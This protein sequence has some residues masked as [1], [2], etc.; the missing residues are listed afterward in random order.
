MSFKHN[1]VVR[2]NNLADFGIDKLPLGA[3]VQQGNN[4]YVLEDTSGLTSSTSISTAITNSNLIKRTDSSEFDSLVSTVGTKADS[5]TVTALTSVV[6]DK[7]DP[8]DYATSTTG[9]TVKMRLNG[10]TLYLRNDGTNA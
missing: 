6:N 10:T 1:S 3:L 9:G 4:L 5:S 2:F 8:N 7:V